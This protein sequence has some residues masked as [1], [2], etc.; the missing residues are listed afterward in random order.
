MTTDAG[1][2]TSRSSSD[3]SLGLM[4]VPTLHEPLQTADDFNFDFDGDFDVSL[5]LGV[6]IDPSLYHEQS[7]GNLQVAPNLTLKTDFQPSEV[8]QPLISNEQYMSHPY[9]LADHSSYNAQQ[10]YAYPEPR[11]H[12][13]H[14]APYFNDYSYNNHYYE[15][16]GLTAMPGSDFFA[17]FDSTQHATQMHLYQVDPMQAVH[18]GYIPMDA[19]CEVTTT[20]FATYPSENPQAAQ[21]VITELAD[22][23]S[24]S[25]EYRDDEEYSDK[26]PTASLASKQAKRKYSRK[27]TV[28]SPSSSAMTLA[29]PVKYSPGE[30]P[31]KDDEKPWVRINNNTEGDTRTAK[32][33]KWKNKYEY[34]PLPLGNWSSGKYTMLYTQ[35]AKTDFLTELPM[36]TRKIEE[37]IL[38][39]PADEEKRLVLWIQKKPADAARR[40]GSMEH[41]KCVFRDCP[42]QRYMEGTIVT[43]EYLVAFDEKYYTYKDQVNPYDCVAYAHLYC[44][45]QYLDFEQ[46]CQVAD[47]RV[48]TR[49]DMPLEPNGKA[50]FSMV[51]VP[52][53]YEMER[54]V[55]AANKGKLRETQRWYNY[56]VHTDYRRG[57]QKPHERTLTYL[58]HRMY[59]EYQDNSHRRQAAGRNVTVSQRRVHLGD[60]E[61]STADKRIQVEVFGGKNKAR[62]QNLKD[63][64]DQKI[65]YQIARAEQEAQDLL[66]Q[67]RA[68]KSS[69]KKYKKYYKS[70]H[71]MKRK[72]ADREESDDERSDS[73]YGQKTRATR[74][75]KQR[76]NY[77]ESPVDTRQPSYQVAYVQSQPVRPAE[78]SEEQIRQLQAYVATS[79]ESTPEFT[80]TQSHA[81]TTLET[82]YDL[83]AVPATPNFDISDFPLEDDLP[84][85]N[86]EQLL[87]LERR[88]SLAGIGPSS[89]LKSPDTSRGGRTPRSAVFRRRAMF[90]AQPVSQS[91]EYRVND[92]PSLM[93][94]RRSARLQAKESIGERRLRERMP[95]C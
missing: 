24:D 82:P 79:L 32:I 42:I 63:Y 85:D 55:K 76:V 52:A 27:S 73:A 36:S 87:A 95:L 67:K 38:N 58:A 70:K 40:Y 88:Q 1:R 35:Y 60:L 2:S 94:G 5:D 72:T 93:S 6:N 48:D 45:E 51:D 64:Y 34:K 9:D 14:E 83:Y 80:Q 11:Y 81:D 56:P 44:M 20:Q 26:E 30:K 92:P 47:V 75:K 21:A 23:D 18:T 12:S 33:N 31:Q 15:T 7:L 68:G 74:H 90:G 16:F 28:S 89:I 77:A 50:S 39:Y 61:I 66:N 62:G 37:Y 46:V 59:E 25:D 3:I 53:R 43:G 19:S 22:S 10:N 69:T 49:L 84:D 91:K 65:R 86:L 8:S 78:A 54:F 57:Q 17:K 4:G 41:S 29:E 71:S 13:A